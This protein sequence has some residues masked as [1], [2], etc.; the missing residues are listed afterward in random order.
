MEGKNEAVVLEVVPYCIAAGKE[1]EI[2]I[3]FLHGSGSKA[4]VYLLHDDM[5]PQ[6]IAANKEG[7]CASWKLPELSPGILNVVIA[8]ESDQDQT[9]VSEVTPVP[10]LPAKAADEMQ[11]IFEE[12]MNREL[13]SFRMLSRDCTLRGEQRSAMHKEIWRSHIRSFAVD[14][15]FLLNDMDDEGEDLSQ[16]DERMDEA[17]LNVFRNL[18]LFLKKSKAP[19][20]IDYLML[21][22]QERGVI[23]FCTSYTVEAASDANTST[24]YEIAP[25]FS[26]DTTRS[27]E[28]TEADINND[29]ET[30]ELLQSVQDNQGG[31][32]A[33]EHSCVDRLTSFD[34]FE[35]FVQAGSLR[36]QEDASLRSED[37]EPPGDHSTL[38]GPP[39]ADSPRLESEL[40]GFNSVKVASHTLPLISMTCIAVLTILACIFLPR[41]YDPGRSA[42][43]MLVSCFTFRCANSIFSGNGTPL[44]VLALFVL[45]CWLYV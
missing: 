21:A 27:E 37:V 38:T 32:E 20:T 31:Q 26:D 13:K 25:R 22:C 30:A 45:C 7:T 43:I 23:S 40:S 6:E 3:N 2:K 33:A 9:L 12:T 10:V 19:A 34:T 42:L 11:R 41:S 14:L 1:E 36:S 24:L 29:P 16:P 18:L 28:H 44:P 35:E 4:Q 39:P 5:P 8:V 17:L 15:D